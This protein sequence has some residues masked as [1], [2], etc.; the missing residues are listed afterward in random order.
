[1][2]VTPDKQTADKHASTRMEVISATARRDTHLITT[3]PV[4]TSMNVAQTTETA[5]RVVIIVW[6]AT[7]VHVQE[8][9]H[10]WRMVDPVQMTTS[11]PVITD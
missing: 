6:V 2:N 3:E 7:A 11:V 4:Q 8:G 10:L 5:S 9:T 1:M